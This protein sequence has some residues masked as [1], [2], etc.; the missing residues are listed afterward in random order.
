MVTFL[1]ESDFHWNIHIRND[2]PD[3]IKYDFSNLKKTL[4]WSL[5]TRAV[6]Y[7]KTKIY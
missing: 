1:I 2:T 7:K 3:E 5:I 6:L 4:G